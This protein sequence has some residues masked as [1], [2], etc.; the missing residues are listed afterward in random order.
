MLCKNCGKEI[1]DS[2]KFCPKCGCKNESANV[3]ISETTSEDNVSF[4]SEETVFDTADEKSVPKPRI[5]QIFLSIIC[6]LLLFIFLTVTVFLCAVRFS[7][8]E[9]NI[10]KILT[11]GSVSDS[12]IVT[13]FGNQNLSKFI[14]S[15]ID[16]SAIRQYKISEDSV[17]SI[18][19][20]ETVDLFLKEV[21][22]DYVKLFIYGEAPVNL[23]ANTIT[24]F[25]KSMANTIQ[26]YTGYT[27]SENDYAS[28]ANQ[29]NQGSLS[30]LTVRGLENN[31]GFN[32]AN[33]HIFFSVPCICTFGGLSLVLIVLVFLINKSNIKNSLSFN[34]VSLIIIA[35]VY[36]CVS[37]ISFIVAATKQ[38][39]FVSDLLK[40]F[41]LYILLIGLGV[42]LIGLLMLLIKRKATK[43][44]FDNTVKEIA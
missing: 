44:S 29:L 12:Y 27:L 25:I 37:A 40:S 33:L 20:E 4:I 6:D 41:A 7:T 26:L 15:N 10:K 42:L 17:I 43:S 13:D 14:L 1:P 39:Y 24:A 35:C 2:T 31:L 3:I 36:V 9:S 16:E 19:K 18:L 23:N 28:I 5:K 21:L 38:L 34:G 32:P 30:F 22:S 11:N 8:N